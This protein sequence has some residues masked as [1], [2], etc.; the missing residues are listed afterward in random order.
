MRTN[1]DREY[2]KCGEELQQSSDPLDVLFFTVCLNSNTVKLVTDTL[3]DLVTVTQYKKEINW[4]VDIP[5]DIRIKIEKLVCE[6]MLMRKLMRQPRNLSKIQ[7][8]CSEINS[9]K[10]TL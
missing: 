5:D 2:C 1:N 10:L 4:L 9:W 3:S 7:N 8:L 6:I